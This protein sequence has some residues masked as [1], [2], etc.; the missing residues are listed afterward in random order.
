MFNM[1]EFKQ[2]TKEWLKENPDSSKQ[3]FLA[4]CHN[5]LP[6][7]QNSKYSWLIDQVG[8]W[9]DNV[10]FNREKIRRIRSRELA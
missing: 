6:A 3:D 1:N 2:K 8:S 7:D 4:F 10:T 5:L 9:F